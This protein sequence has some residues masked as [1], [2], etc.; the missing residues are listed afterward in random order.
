MS[1]GGS[2]GVVVVALACNLGIALAKF[3]AAAWTGSSAM[4]SEA[5]HS[6]VDTCN[7]V[8]LLGLRRAGR[9]ADKR[10]PFGYSTGIYFWSFI[11]ATLLLSLGSATAKDAAQAAV[12]K[13][14][15]AA[16]PA[17]APKP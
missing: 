9:P 3:A 12:H 14:M 16:K 7:R 17:E 2:A 10:H 1:A 4:L 8:L 11:V 13:A 6:L 15:D 5:V